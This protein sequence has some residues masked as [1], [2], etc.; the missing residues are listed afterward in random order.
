MLKKL[1]K[2]LF[3][4]GLSMPS[5]EGFFLKVRCIECREDFNL[6]INTSTDLLQEFDD[7]GNIT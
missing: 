1:V 7:R 4:N 2:K 6:F 3:G 5:S